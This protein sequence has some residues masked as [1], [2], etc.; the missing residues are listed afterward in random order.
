MTDLVVRGGTVVTAERSLETDIAVTDGRITAIG[1]NLP[2]EPGTEVVDA[3]GLL[4]LPR[5]VDVYPHPAA[6]R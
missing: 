4:V 6:H 1:P 2:Q 5:C 3:G